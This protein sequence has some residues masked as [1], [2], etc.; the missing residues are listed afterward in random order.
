MSKRPYNSTRI[1]GKQLVCKYLRSNPQLRQY[2]PHTLTLSQKNLKSMTRSYDSIYI[3]PDV[4]SLGIGVYK[5]VRLSAG[6]KLYSTHKKNQVIKHF[7]TVSALYKHLKSRHSSKM[8]IQRDVKLDHV[9]GRPYD[10][11]VMVQRKPRQ[12]WT[13]TGF[14]VKVGA[15]RKIVTNYYQGGRIYSLDRLMTMKQYSTTQ[16]KLTR[17]TLTVTALKVARALSQK[18]SGMHEMGIDFAYGR[19]KRLWILEVNSNHPQFYP[20]KKVDP[21]AYKRMLSYARSY[22]RR[23]S[24]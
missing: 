16:R 3:K 20:L 19:N 24:K 12:P 10:L 13:C 8:I 23:S 5:V 14:I 6:Y 1:R 2:V 15:P 18:R 4:G 22:G 21:K 9:Q 17:R 7:K 11:R